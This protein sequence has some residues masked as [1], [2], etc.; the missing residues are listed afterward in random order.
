MIQLQQVSCTFNPGTPQE[1]PALRDVS[2]QVESNDFCV[3]LGPNG[4]GKSTLLQVIAGSVKPQQGKVC[5]GALDLTRL[6]EHRRSSRIGRLFQNPLAGTAP[7]L[8]ILENFRLAALRTRRKWM[9]PGINRNFRQGV[10]DS[11]SRLGMGLESRLNQPVGQLSGGQ[12]QAL[13][14]LMATFDD[15]E[16]LLMD[17]P[18]AA[19]DPRS[20]E[21]VMNL[22]AQLIAEK[23]I[24]A[25][26]VTHRLQDA[27]KYG[28]RVLFM[29]EG[30]LVHD[31]DERARKELDAV[32]LLNW[33]G[34][35]PVI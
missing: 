17:E 1:T 31:Y 7:D 26:L 14:L 35:E 28:N 27:L 16:V 33:F 34:Q 4:S 29:K 23:K 22:A 3:V 32:Q 30:K 6:P 21:L 5:F 13:T 15:C 2:L 9:L 8:S 24:S 25:L 11:I 20:S 18:V 12:R 19:L 10:A